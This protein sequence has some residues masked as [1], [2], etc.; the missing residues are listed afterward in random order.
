MSKLLLLTGNHPRHLYL[1][2][3]LA[4]F[5][6]VVGWVIEDRGEFLQ[7]TSK[8]SEDIS[9]NKLC[10]LHF[11]KRYL[12]EK[13]FFLD[14]SNIDIK[15]SNF[16]TNVSK[17]IIRCSK[18]DLNSLS[19]SNFINGI[20][21]D[22]SITYGTHILDNSILNL[23]PIEK[24]NIHGGISPWYKG[25][26]THFW[27]SY[28]LEP[29]MTGLTMHRLTAVLDGGPILHQNTGILVRGDGLHELSCRTV[30]SFFS[31]LSEIINKISLREYTLI[32]QK[33]SGKLWLSSDWDPNHLKVIYNQFED[34]IVD[35][36]LDNDISKVRKK[37]I[38]LI[39]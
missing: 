4:N 13:R 24:Y 2:G 9:L 8:Y 18:K 37:I 38:R 6:D 28:L 5:H 19:I 16:Y 33:S 31:E 23:L 32:S 7:T 39:N 14:D 30:K 29:Q 3:L 11:K 34:K 12:A 25:C 15:A 35:Y 20:T 26:I 1:A 36:C 21:A 10:S 27:P 22:I 17:N